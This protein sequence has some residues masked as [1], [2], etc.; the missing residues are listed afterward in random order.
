MNNRPPG[1]PSPTQT[2]ARVGIS[3]TNLRV[4]TPAD[5][6]STAEVLSPHT[7]RFVASLLRTFAGSR[8][9]AQRR[10]AIGHRL[11]TPFPSHPVAR[12]ASRTLENRPQLAPFRYTISRR[13]VACCCFGE[14]PWKWVSNNNCSQSCTSIVVTCARNNSACVCECAVFVRDRSSSRFQG[15]LGSLLEGEAAAKAETT[16]FGLTFPPRT[17]HH[18]VAVGVGACL[19]TLECILVPTSSALIKL[20]S[21]I[22]LKTSECSKLIAR[23]NLKVKVIAHP[24]RQNRASISSSSSFRKFS[25]KKITPQISN[26]RA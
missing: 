20:K 16:T 5:R 10:P 19:D 26:K 11:H 7:L 17:G 8:R 25:S 6:R 2:P 9:P 18:P 23:A 24:I 3:S 21:L 15:F 13:L 12:V 14:E 22:N 1:I 4:V